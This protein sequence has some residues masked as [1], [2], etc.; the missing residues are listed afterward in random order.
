MAVKWK[1]VN[2]QG[3]LDS[4]WPGKASERKEGM[5][6][7]GVFEGTRDIT[8][9]D[10]TQDKL[11][12]L[13]GEKGESVGVNNSAGIERA[14]EMIPEKSLVRITYLGKKVNPKTGRS[15]ND[16][17]VDVADDSSSSDETEVPF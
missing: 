12:I 13:R 1:T 9:P 5:S 10:G 17:Q 15:F 8:R 3:A 2:G 11:Y 6:T 4:Y 7:S 14:M 16:F